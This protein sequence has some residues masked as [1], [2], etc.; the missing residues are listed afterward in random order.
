M[1]NYTVVIYD[2]N[3]DV[4][5]EGRKFLAPRRRRIAVASRLFRDA[6]SRL[7]NQDEIVTLCAHRSIQVSRMASS[8]RV[9]ISSRTTA[10]GETFGERTFGNYPELLV[11]VTPANPQNSLQVNLCLQRQ[12][13]K[14]S[15][16]DRARSALSRFRSIT[17]IL[18]YLLRSSFCP[19]CVVD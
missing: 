15:A 7:R 8:V 9:R 19:F 14:E 10:T 18:I 3:P 2:D 12:M 17:W 11:E 16:Q 5:P 4:S 6:A 1:H 13:S